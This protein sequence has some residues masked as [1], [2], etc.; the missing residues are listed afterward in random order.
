MATARRKTLGWV[1]AVA[2]VLF[3]N[4]LSLAAIILAWAPDSP[5]AMVLFLPFPLSLA[6]GYLVKRKMT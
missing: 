3:G 1:L 4:W 5:P 2:T 6:I